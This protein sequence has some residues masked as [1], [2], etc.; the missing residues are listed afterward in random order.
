MVSLLE[1]TLLN[2]NPEFCECSAWLE[3]YT[4]EMFQ[5][6]LQTWLKNGYAEFQYVGN[7][8]KKVAIEMTDKAASHLA[9]GPFDPTK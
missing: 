8:D 7:I 6:E 2:S 4:Y 1:T 5:Q 3:G 9:L